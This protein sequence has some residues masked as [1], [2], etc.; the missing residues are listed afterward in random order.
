MGNDPIVDYDRCYITRWQSIDRWNF[1]RHDRIVV[2]A[3]DERQMIVKMCLYALISHFT[4][5][6]NSLVLCQLLTTG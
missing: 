6:S 3:V 1:V 4:D 5:M 2:A